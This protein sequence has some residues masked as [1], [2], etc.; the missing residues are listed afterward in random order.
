MQHHT[1]GITC[2]NFD[3]GDWRDT[4]GDPIDRHTPATGD[5]AAVAP[6]SLSRDVD[7]AVRSAVRAFATWRK[8]LPAERARHLHRLA[9]VCATR[10][11]ELA[12][13]ITREQGKP[14]NEARG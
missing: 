11:D 8:T 4:H 7:A 10:V 12:V 5:L 1:D 2:R 3:D 13:S 6:R 9:E 14:R